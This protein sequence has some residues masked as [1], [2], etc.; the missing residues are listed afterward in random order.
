MSRLDRDP[1]EQDS[2][3]ANTA[4][5]SPSDRAALPSATGREAPTEEGASEIQDEEIRDK[6]G[7]GRPASDET[8]F[9]LSGTGAIETEDGLDELGEMTRSAAED[10]PDEDA[11]IDRPVFDRGQEI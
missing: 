7:G 11:T 6:S 5:V 3:Y 8:N 1:P 4:E 2:P 10:L 9:H